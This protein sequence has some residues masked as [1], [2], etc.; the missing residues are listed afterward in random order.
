MG[1]TFL[2]SP[3]LSFKNIPQQIKNNIYLTDIDIV[4]FDLASIGYI[5]F[6][7]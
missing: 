6:K 3:L 5:R 1:N 2:H 4:N 7:H